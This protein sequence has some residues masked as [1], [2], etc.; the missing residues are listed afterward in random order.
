MGAG[1]EE[2]DEVIVAPGVGIAGVPCGFFDR[3]AAYTPAAA[4]DCDRLE[5]ADESLCVLWV[6]G[7]EG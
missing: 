2:I 1:I 3:G 7:R 4:T 6:G 5:V